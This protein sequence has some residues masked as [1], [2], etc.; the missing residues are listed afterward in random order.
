[1]KGTIVDVD[2]IAK[3]SIP[4]I[5]K[6][7]T[8]FKLS[9]YEHAYAIY[10]WN[11]MLAGTF[12]P[13]MQAIEVSLRNAMND[14]IS[15]QCG[16]PLWFTRIYRRND[17]PA[18]FPKLHHSVVNR[19]THYDLDLLKENKDPLYKQILQRT[20]ERKIKNGNINIKNSYNQHIVGNLML[21]AW[22]IL[23]T[24][25][26]VDNTH[27]T[28]L[29]PALTNT[30]FPNAVGREKNELFTIYNDI[31]L[32]RNRISHNE[33]ICNP[34]GHFISI[35]ECIES[36]KEKYNKA[37]HSIFL[38]SSKRHKIFIESHASSHFNMVCSKE[39]LNSIIDTYVS[40]KIKI[41]KHCGKKFETFT[42]Q[43]CVCR[44]K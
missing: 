14:A 11:K 3:L 2:I 6:Y 13:V 26:Y 34:N 27:N 43:K 35:D 9:S 10:V 30:V 39:Y 18:N 17:I 28:K 1:M 20:Y 22:V 36:V 8:T 7:K 12:I 5:E 15:T 29:W 38:L 42:N 25:D 23:L 44:R 21:G 41:C 16:S 31:R 24:S 19:Y 37:L 32:L 4:R 33:P 40:G